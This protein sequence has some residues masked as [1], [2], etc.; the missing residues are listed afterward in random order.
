[1]KKITTSIL[2]TLV[3]LS[4][5]IGLFAFSSHSASADSD[6][7]IDMLRC[8]SD[9]NHD[10]HVNIFDILRIR[11]YIAQYEA[12]RTYSILGDLNRDSKIDYG[13]DHIV[14]AFWD[15]HPIKCPADNDKLGAEDWVTKHMTCRTSL[16]SDSIINAEDVF[17]VG[18]NQIDI[19]KNGIV[20]KDDAFLVRG[21]EYGSTLH[22]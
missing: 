11:N 20:N 22:C 2:V 21:Y 7:E 4:A 14:S 8:R 18:T 19:D 1:M 9:F 6:D 17:F 13:D 3:T 15:E 12:D 10:G 5:L 16:T